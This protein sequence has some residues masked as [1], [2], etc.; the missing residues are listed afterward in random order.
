MVAQTSKTSY[1]NHSNS[2]YQIQAEVL[3][4]FQM[5][6]SCHRRATET[7][8]HIKLLSLKPVRCF[9]VTRCHKRV[10]KS[11]MKCWDTWLKFANVKYNLTTA[12]VSW[13]HWNTMSVSSVITAF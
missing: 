5:A 6:S 8:N 10:I 4:E 2:H 1:Y 7:Q 11:E 9:S 3:K 13:L 12:T